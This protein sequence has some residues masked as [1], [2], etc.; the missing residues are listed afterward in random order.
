MGTR[1]VFKVK[2][3]GMIISKQIKLAGKE[4]KRSGGREDERYYR[5][6]EKINFLIL[7]INH[8]LEGI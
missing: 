3:K 5:N 1:K 4:C 8:T 2:G 6:M 7:W